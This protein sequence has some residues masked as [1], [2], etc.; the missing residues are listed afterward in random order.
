MADKQAELEWEARAGKFAA[1]A[2]FIAALAPIASGIALSA[3]LPSRIKNDV[4]QVNALAH[5][6]GAFAMAMVITAVGWLAF[7]PVFGYLLRAARFRVQ[8]PRW[9]DPLIVIGPLL[10]IVALVL[11]LTDVVGRAQDAVPV[12]KQE[13]HD[14]LRD[15]SPAVRGLAAAGALSV[16]IVF[17]MISTYAGRAGLLSRFMTI[18]GSIIGALTVFGTVVGAGSIAGPLVLFWGVALG[19]LFLNRWPGGRGPAWETGEA[20]PWPSGAERQAAAREAAGEEAEEND[21]PEA[22]AENTQQ[23]NQRAA[24]KRKKKKARR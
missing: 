9:I 17:V 22:V 2:A 21:E 19:M 13:A 10:L 11:Q 23:P 24:R 3:A 4:D 8:V 7:I 15:V 16:G 14:L 18:M 5:H 6:S 20:V 1:I 12:T